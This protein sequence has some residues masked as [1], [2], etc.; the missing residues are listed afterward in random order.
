M[1]ISQVSDCMFHSSLCCVCTRS[2]LSCSLLGVNCSSTHTVHL[3]AEVDEEESDEVVITPRTFLAGDI[4]FLAAM[5]GRE[6]YDGWWCMW[7]W[8]MKTNYQ[9]GWCADHKQPLHSTC[10]HEDCTHDQ[11]L[12]IQDIIDQYN[13]NVANGRYNTGSDP[14]RKGVA[15]EPIINEGT[16]VLAPGLH[17]MMGIADILISYHFD[18]IDLH[19]EPL[20]RD[21]LATR[22][23]IPKNEKLLEDEEANLGI[24]KD[25]IDGGMKLTELKKES[26][27]LVKQIEQYTAASSNNG[28][29]YNNA[30]E[31]KKDVDSRIEALQ[32]VQLNHQNKIKLLKKEIKDA[33]TNWEACRTARKSSSQSIYNKCEDILIKNGIKRSA[34]HGGKFNGVN[35]VQIMNK[36]TK[37]YDEM[38]QVML[39]EGRYKEGNDN[40]KKIV[41]EFCG[42][43]SSG[44][45]LWNDIFA[46][47]SDQKADMND[48]YCDETQQLINVAMDQMRKLNF[49]ITPKLH[50]VETHIVYQMR[51]VPG[52]AY[53]LEQWI[54]HYHQIGHRMDVQW[55]GQQYEHQARLRANKETALQACESKEAAAKFGK[56]YGVKK[57]KRNEAVVMKEN[58][59]K[60]E[61]KEGVDKV[62]AMLERPIDD[63]EVEV[64]EDTSQ[65]TGEDTN[66][67][68]VSRA[69]RIRRAPNRDASEGYRR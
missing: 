32:T 39:A 53:M 5:L 54:E 21:E 24:W 50:V 49:S 42:Q 57:R 63:E 34:Y 45:I 6:G 1:K 11:G 31:R 22:E 33:K 51:T 13:D 64:V 47:I 46:R 28:D 15:M 43:V 35:I 18:M 52:F 19:V 59:I 16:T 7:C 25:S 48:E 29:N 65:T 58:K 8:L 36:A 14:S 67:A 10:T 27:R 41:E 26:K 44:L 20:T 23:S 30:V 40:E 68:T 9:L 60:E 2:L 56:Y 55:K 69:G 62:L 12:K 37:I 66:N 38:H 3:V 4:A 61:R 17:L